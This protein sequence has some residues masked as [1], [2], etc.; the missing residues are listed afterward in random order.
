MTVLHQNIPKQVRWAVWTSKHSDCWCLW[1]WW[2]WWSSSP[3]VAFKNAKQ[4]EQAKEAYLQE[5]EAHTNNRTY[6][7]RM[8][9]FWWISSCSILI[10]KCPWL[11]V[12]SFS[13][14][15]VSKFIIITDAWFF[16]VQIIVFVY[17][18]AACFCMQ[19][20]WA[21]RNDAEG[22]CCSGVILHLIS[23]KNIFYWK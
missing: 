1:W 15:Q 14:C 13:C 5:A 10:W 12:Q 3:A 21:S 16:T 23:T 22:Q 7:C 2:W 17:E 9:L 20:L 19:G 4:L 11:T 18:F 8:L 6:P